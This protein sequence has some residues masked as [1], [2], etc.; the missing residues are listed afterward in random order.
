MVLATHYL[1]L[2]LLLTNVTSWTAFASFYLFFRQALPS[3]TKYS[4]R[5]ITSNLTPLYKTEIQRTRDSTTKNV[6]QKSPSKTP[7]RYF[8]I[9]TCYLLLSNDI[10]NLIWSNINEQL[11]NYWLYLKYYISISWI[12]KPDAIKLIFRLFELWWNILNWFDQLYI[13]KQ[14]EFCQPG[15]IKLIC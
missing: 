2:Y 8:L 4:V 3:N 11:T 15:A 14:I 5:V 9:A 13:N 10:F 7:L 6:S 1:L 12:F